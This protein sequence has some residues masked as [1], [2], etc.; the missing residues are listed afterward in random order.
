MSQNSP[1]AEVAIARYKPLI[2]ARA[3]QFWRGFLATRCSL[4]DLEAVATV[5][6]WEASKHWRKD[7][8][9]AFGTYVSHAVEN[10]LLKLN[11]YWGRGR[12]RAS[13]VS[14]SPGPDGQLQVDLE[15]PDA[16]ASERV[17]VESWRAEVR[18]VV[19]RLRPRHREVITL[20]YWQDQLQAEVGYHLG[21]T[22]QRVQQI[23]AEALDALRPK[24]RHLWSGGQAA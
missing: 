2:K 23:E 15:S 19:D 18:A 5:A 16:T 22:R 17:E 1:S 8:G 20:R 12:R 21:V 9:A 24:L 11:S 7:G 6:V 3:R 14:L 13:F 10:E 4:Q